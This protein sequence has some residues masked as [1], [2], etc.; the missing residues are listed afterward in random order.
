MPAQDNADVYFT[1]EVPCTPC[2]LFSQH[3]QEQEQLHLDKM[4]DLLVNRRVRPSLLLPIW[5]IAGYVL[6]AGTA[7]LGK[8]AAMA[9]TVAVETSIGSHYNSQIRDMLERRY[10][11]SEFLDIVKQNRDEELEHLD[12]GMQHNAEQ[13]PFY[14]ALSTAIQTGCKASVWLAQRV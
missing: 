3:M 4:S 13:A 5:H 6:G 7:L 12:T 14:Q 9:C 1:R 8:E 2:F 10:D 11:E